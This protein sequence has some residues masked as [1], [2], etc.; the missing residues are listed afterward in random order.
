VQL[1]D[2]LTVGGTDRV[3]LNIAA[4]NSHGSSAPHPRTWSAPCAEPRRPCATTSRSRSGTPATPA[5]VQ[6]A[7]DARLTFT[8]VDAFQVEAGG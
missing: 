8:Y 7:G 4:L 2:S 1:P 3:D 6:A 5:A